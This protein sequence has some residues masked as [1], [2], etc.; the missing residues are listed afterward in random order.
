MNDRFRMRTRQKR[1]FEALYGHQFQL[2]NAQTGAGKS[3]QIIFSSARE[4]DENPKQAAT[5]GADK[6]E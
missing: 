6:H 3:L 2:L 1:A 4:M 5:I